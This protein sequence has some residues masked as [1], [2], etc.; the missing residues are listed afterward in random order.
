MAASCGEKS[1]NAEDYS[2]IPIT[3]INGVTV[4]K[5]I[6]APHFTSICKID[7]RLLLSYMSYA[8]NAYV[9]IN[10]G[11]GKVEKR[12]GGFGDGPEDFIC[13]ELS[14]ISENED[15]IFAFDIT[16][17]HTVEYVR[18]STKNDYKFHK[19]H[20]CTLKEPAYFFDLKRMDNGCFVG[21]LIGGKDFMFVL[22]DKNLKEI[23]R[24]GKVPIK[25]LTAD[26]VDFTPLCGKIA[27][28]GNSIFFCMQEY[29]YMARYDIKE[30]G[31]IDL[32]WEHFLT[33]PKYIIEDGQR[34]KAIGHENTSG[35]YSIAANEK[36]LFLLYS[37]EYT[38][39]YRDTNDPSANVPNTLLVFDTDG[40]ILK[41]CHFRD[42]GG[43]MALSPDNE[44]IYIDAENPEI[45]IVAYKMKDILN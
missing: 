9:F 29:A 17:M 2:S 14:G 12:L 11:T 21:Q 16:R 40:K 31:A 10:E 23:T 8:E 37:G 19:G 33:E 38:L 45:S 26:Q 24:F 13:Q 30:S 44:T 6:L 1:Y 15:T 20:S 32:V 43:I 25:G 3:E 42:K 22:L 41:K 36:Y 27:T 4:T 39:K 7:G 5:D 18:D 34:I 35:F 28:I